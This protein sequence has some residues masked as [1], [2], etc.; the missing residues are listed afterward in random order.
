MINLIQVLMF[1][2]LGVALWFEAPSN[3]TWITWFTTFAVFLVAN[4]RR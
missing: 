3:I 1:T 4:F 2:L